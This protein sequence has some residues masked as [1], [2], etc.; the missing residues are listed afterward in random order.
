MSSGTSTSGQD[1]RRLAGA[2]AD[3]AGRLRAQADRMGAGAAGPQQAGRS[4]EQVG[5]A[6]LRALELLRANVESFAAHA[7]RLSGD[8]DRCSRECGA[9]DRSAAEDLRGV[10]S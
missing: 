7:E 8:L 3:A 4:F 5:A 2:F 10:R 6:Y 1:V 9:A